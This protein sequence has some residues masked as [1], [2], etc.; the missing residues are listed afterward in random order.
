M[1]FLKRWPLSHPLVWAIVYFIGLGSLSV[2]LG[3]DVSWD[4]RNYHFYNPYMLLTWRVNYDILPAQIQTF[5]NP[6]LDIPFFVAIYSLKFPPVVV[7]FLLGGFHGLNQWFVH[8]IAYYSLYK[9]SE[10][11]RLTLSILAAITSIIGAAYLSELG[12]SIGDSTSSVFILAGLFLMIYSLSRSGTVSLKILILAGVIFG[13]AT[14]LK[15]TTALYS[16]ALLVAINFLPNSFREKLRNLAIIIP[17]MAAGFSLTMGYWI[18]FMWTN[19]SNPVFPFFNKIFRSPYIETDFNFQDLRFLPKDIW[20]FL[21]YPFYFWHEPPL[22]AELSF[23]ETRFAIA[24]ILIGITIG[25]IVY[26]RVSG[27]S[28]SSTNEIIHVP[29][30][31]FLLP[32]YLTAYGIWLKNF[33]IYRYL[34][35]LELITPVLFFL[36]IAYLY[37]HRKPVFLV[38]VALFSLVAVTVRPL[39]WWRIDWSD[40]YFHID[41]QAL[42]KYENDVIVFWGG[43][44]TAYVVPYFPATT[45][46]VRI[47]GN[48]GLSPR[49]L[50]SKRASEILKNTPEKSLY[51]LEVNFERESREK[52]SAK[53]TDL[54]VHNL[55]IDR[56][57]CE[58][59]ITAIEKYSLCPLVRNER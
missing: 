28:P 18:V 47:T 10:I 21:F 45:R 42:V 44:P 38:T 54:A 12:T 50:M 39:D 23:R 33:S 7:G 32:F 35:V 40:N 29:I 15:L 30:L 25:A 46:F 37:P 51:L 48:F 58:P 14:G 3:Q 16:I 52:E 36:I 11:Y 5:F 26:R 6:L 41:K 53:K 8:L 13:L 43:E 1:A 34:L 2:I 22:T 56:S 20:Q 57:R 19:F 17:A 27:R 59:F 55:K 24:Y 49:T 31:F 9:V 4:L